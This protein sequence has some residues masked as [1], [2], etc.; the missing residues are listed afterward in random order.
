[1]GLRLREGV[2]LAR[3]AGALAAAGLARMERQQ[4]VERRAGRLFARPEG[5]LLFNGLLAEIA[6]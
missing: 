2:E 3:V 6:A 5:M 4:L 1:M